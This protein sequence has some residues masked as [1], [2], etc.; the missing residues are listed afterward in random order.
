V[1]TLF[2]RAMSAARQR[3]KEMGQEFGSN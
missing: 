2:M 1:K 3:A